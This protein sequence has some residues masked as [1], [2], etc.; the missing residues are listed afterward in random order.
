MNSKL[1]KKM[2]LL[3]STIMVV[4]FLFTAC[5][6]G[7][8]NE[9]VDAPKDTDQTEDIDKD[10]EDVEDVE[11]E[12]EDVEDKDEDVEDKDEEKKDD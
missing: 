2:A 1:F 11:D 8:D 5:G 10:N 12:D 3:L 4:A 6:G 9:G 7:N